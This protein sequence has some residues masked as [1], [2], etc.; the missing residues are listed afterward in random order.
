[1]ENKLRKTV[2]LAIAFGTSVRDVLRNDTFKILS[3]NK[4]VK[5]VIFAVNLSDEFK[6]EFRG[7]N[8]E[9][10]SLE[11]FSPSKAE[12]A[13]LHFHRA[14]LRDRCKTIDLGNTSGD[15]YA[16]DKFT[17][18]ARVF[19][20]LLGGKIVNKLV[21]YLYMI[22][23]PSRHYTEI[24]KKYKP[25][26]VLL[27]RVLNFS[28]DYPLLRA[29]NSHNVPAIAL[30]SS[31]DNL[32]SKAFFPF[33]LKSLVVWNEVIKKEALDLFY[34]PEKDIFISGIPRFDLFFTK[35]DIDTRQKFCEKM[36]LDPEAKVIFYCTGSDATGITKM[37]LKSPESDIAGFLAENIKNGY[38][39]EKVQLLVRLHPQ[40]IPDDYM[41]LNDYSNVKLHIPGAKSAFQDRLF[42]IKDDLE[43]IE[44]LKYS[45]VIV[46]LASTVTID[47]AVFDLPV[48]C[49]NFDFR[50]ERP[51]KYSVKRLYYFDHY[52]KLGTTNGYH[53]AD[54]R[55][56]LLHCID[57]NLKYPYILRLG[58]KRIV[59]MQCYFT[60]GKSG[61]RVGNY[62]L[63]KIYEN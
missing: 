63:D 16:L 56:S 57:L 9:F 45:N 2:F 10:E 25:D 37:D 5:I 50:G 29:A 44:S 13:V 23:S 46:N 47:A 59:N 34:F 21:Y 36:G 11:V 8:I 1:L 38:F 52:A 54:S 28:A 58:R 26:L 18:I 33:R 27:T 32:T 49:I 55:E 39:K 60:D 53:M 35:Q 15:T 61:E 31:W 14:T 17:P 7:E 12:R 30:I 41:F 6:K 43:F 48:I 62:I 20:F 19:L 24:F 42:S 40:A 22:F 3:R 51:F 4:N